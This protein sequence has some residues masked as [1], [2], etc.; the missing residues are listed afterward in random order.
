MAPDPSSADIILNK[1]ALLI[2]KN[3][4]LVSSWLPPPVPSSE[5]P[6]SEAEIEKEEQEIFGTPLP[7]LYVHYVGITVSRAWGRG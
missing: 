1:A 6:K 5:P 3:Q 2:A 7:E 4:R